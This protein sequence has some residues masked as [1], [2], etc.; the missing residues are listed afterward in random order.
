MTYD[1]IVVGAGL[2]GST[3]AERLASD[4]N[5]HVLIIDKR[6]T[7]GG[8]VYDY[9]D[10]GILVHQYGPHIFHTNE[11]DVFDY[12][13]NFT[14]RKPYEHRVLGMVDGHIVPIP[15]NITSIR[16]CFPKSKAYHLIEV[17]INSFGM[18]KRVPILKLREHGDP[19]IRELAEYINAS[20]CT[21]P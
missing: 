9:D 15:F 18:D 4:P 7:I 20:S 5:K 11:K 8:N 17:L 1:Y 14:E 16:D 2:A 6:E 21:T 12:L 13:S 19:E 3:I 10:D